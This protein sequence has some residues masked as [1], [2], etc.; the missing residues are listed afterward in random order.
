M[1]RENIGQNIHGSRVSSPSGLL[2]QQ[3]RDINAPKAILSKRA[4][5]VPS[6]Y[7][8]FDSNI[9]AAILTSSTVT[10]IGVIAGGVLIALLAVLLLGVLPC[11][12][13]RRRSRRQKAQVVDTEKVTV[14]QAPHETYN[15][16]TVRALSFSTLT[17]DLVLMTLKADA[18]RKASEHGEGREPEIRYYALSRFFRN[19]RPNGRDG[20]TTQPAAAHSTIRDTQSPLIAL[21]PTSPPWRQ[22]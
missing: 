7:T 2:V 18:V 3:L 1:S 17:F 9:T 15:N 21:A 6:R 12:L 4:K 20:R 16:E 22:D 19:R 14:T 5:Y 11:Y 13:K 10:G 8:Y